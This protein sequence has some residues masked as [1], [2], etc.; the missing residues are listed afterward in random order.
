MELGLLTGAAPLLEEPG[1]ESMSSIVVEDELRCSAACGIF[2]TEPPGK[3]DNNFLKLH[4]LC[5][6]LPTSTNSSLT[7]CVQPKQTSSV[8]SPPLSFSPGTS[9]FFLRLFD[10]DPPPFFVFIEFITMSVFFFFL[11]ERHM[12]S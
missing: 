6:I 11:A 7:P 2:T 10:V 9:F 3:P 4:E 5:F 8:C 1:F 12:E